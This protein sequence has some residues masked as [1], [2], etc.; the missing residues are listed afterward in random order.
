M[1]SESDNF[2]HR[3]DWCNILYLFHFKS[4]RNIYFTDNRYVH[5]NPL[6]FNKIAQCIPCVAFLFNIKP[7]NIKV[8]GTTSL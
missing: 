6:S 4:E 5:N 1:A 2:L 3:E 7:Y 8:S